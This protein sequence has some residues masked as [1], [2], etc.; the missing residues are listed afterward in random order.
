MT[1]DIDLYATLTAMAGAVFVL[2]IGAWT[3]STFVWG[4]RLIIT[5]LFVMVAYAAWDAR[6]TA[7]NHP[8][9]RPEWFGAR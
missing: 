4:E 5:G 3:S 1:E 9:H 2:T 8:T 6:K 7:T